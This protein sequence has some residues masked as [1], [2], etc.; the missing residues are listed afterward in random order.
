MTRL[1]RE[2]TTMPKPTRE[3]FRAA[4]TPAD[5]RALQIIYLAIALGVAL[6]ALVVVALYW[7]QT[8]AVAPTVIQ[9]SVV[10]LLTLVHV[11]TAATVYLF[12]GPL[13]YR[14]VLGTEASGEGSGEGGDVLRRIRTAEIVRLA[15]IEGVA[16]VGLVACLLGVLFGVL[17]EAP[18]YWLNLFSTFV[19]LGFVGRNLPTAERLEAVFRRYVESRPGV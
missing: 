6:F 12:A 14:K 9:A 4:L 18:V 7:W 1:V 2:R 11:F 15:L 3:A 8:E 13:V 17:R 19:L 10:Q 5:V 16:M